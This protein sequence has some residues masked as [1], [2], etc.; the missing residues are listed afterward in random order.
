MSNAQHGITE[1]LVFGERSEIYEKLWM[2]AT[3]ALDRGQPELDPRLFDKAG[4]LRRAVTLVLRPSPAVCGGVRKFLDLLEREFPEQ[5]YYRSEEIHVTVASVVVGSESWRK[6]IRHLAACRA[7]I[8]QVLAR[9]QA[10][11][12]RFQ[13]VTAS[14]GCVLIQ[15]F[16]ADDGLS[17]IREELHKAFERAGFAGMLD[18]RYRPVAAHLTVARFRDPRSDWRRL[19]SMLRENR[20]REFGETEVGSLQLIWGDWYASA[21][22]VRLLREYPLRARA[23]EHRGDGGGAR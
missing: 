16:P 5:H 15:G 10:F 13:G 6:E 20:C 4:D 7:L 19:A 21:D 23:T 9:R 3:A 22:V 1:T 2:Q 11:T 8:G 17:E 12:I 18:R 14:P